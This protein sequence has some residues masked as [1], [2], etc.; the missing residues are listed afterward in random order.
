MEGLK[1]KGQ[2]ILA[3]ESAERFQSWTANLSVSIWILRGDLFLALDT[4]SCSPQQISKHMSGWCAANI[5]QA[6][7]ISQ[8]SR[9]ETTERSD[10]LNSKH[11]DS[12][13]YSIYIS[14]VLKAALLA[15]ATCW[16]GC[17]PEASILPRQAADGVCR[18]SL[19]SKGAA[20]HM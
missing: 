18:C 19:H 1:G 5:Q 6:V 3:P 13:P 2:E 17:L 14:N 9:L 4:L 7:K 20:R 16:S 15:P 11:G 12:M 10:L 8:A